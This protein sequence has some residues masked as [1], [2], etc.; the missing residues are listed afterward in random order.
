MISPA[1]F[2]TNELAHGRVAEA[3]EHC[4]WHARSQARVPETP[5]DPWREFRESLNRLIA[6]LCE[7]RGSL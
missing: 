4:I 3:L 1:D 2:I 6:D 5:L 7:I